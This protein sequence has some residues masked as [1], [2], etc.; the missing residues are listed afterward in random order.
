MRAFIQLKVVMNRYRPRQI[1]NGVSL[2]ILFEDATLLVVD[3]PAGIDVEELAA[4]LPKGSTPAHRVVKIPPR[5]NSKSS[6]K[7]SLRNFYYP[8]HR[9][10]K[11]TSGV[12]VVAKTPEALEFLRK[13]LKERK[14]QKRYLCLVEG[15]LK[16][17]EGIVHTLLARSPADRRKQRTFPL[18]EPKEGRREAVSEWKVAERL[19]GCTLL[20]VSPKT[21]RKHQIRAHMASLGTPVAGDK[22]YGFKNQKVPKGLQR[23]FLHAASLTIALPAGDQKTF[24]SELPEE[25]QAVLETLQNHDN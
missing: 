5:G 18:E 1:T 19:E 10:D 4:K 12:L 13:Q 16:Q 11:E 3:K 23:Q 7:R 24:H 25:L 9:L 21:G 6:E 15:T 17:D 20:E 8:A 22:L 2:K 14:A